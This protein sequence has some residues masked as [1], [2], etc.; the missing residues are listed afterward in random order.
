MARAKAGIVTDTPFELVGDVTTEEAVQ[1]IVLTLSNPC[2]YI[3]ITLEIPPESVGKSRNV[4]FSATDKVVTIEC[5]HRSQDAK[6]S[7]THRAIYKST[8]EIV[9]GEIISYGGISAATNTPVD[10]INRPIYG[11]LAG[12]G[13]MKADSFTK[14][15]VFTY[16][17]AFPAGSKVN[18][19]GC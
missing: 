9:G 5:F 4:Y 8:A 16:G 2:R 1:S 14:I 6:T 7:E 13:G 10:Y 3:S 15:C 12:Y 18:I 19:Y 11:V 17:T